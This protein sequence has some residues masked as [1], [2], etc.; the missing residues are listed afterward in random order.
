M[1]K[2]NS[3]A[4]SSKLAPLD[5][6]EGTERASKIKKPYPCLLR[7]AELKAIIAEQLG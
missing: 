4:G 6:R 2:S 3:A 5:Q 1:T 7:R